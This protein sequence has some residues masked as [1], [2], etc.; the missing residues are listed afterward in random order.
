MPRGPQGRE[1]GVRYEQSRNIAGD[2]AGAVRISGNF[3]SDHEE[4]ILNLIKREGKL[5]EERNSRARITKIEKANGGIIVETSDQ[6]LAMKIGKSLQS[7]YK[8]EHQYKYRDGDKF[9]EVNW[10]RD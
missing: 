10:R 2:S 8:G 5:S 9:I 6:H 3:I 1:K 7:A 4:E